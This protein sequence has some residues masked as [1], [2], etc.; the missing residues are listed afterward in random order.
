[1][2]I[3]KKGIFS[4]YFK[5]IIIPV[6]LFSFITGT[7]TGA[8]V[9]GYRYVATKIISYSQQIYSFLRNNLIYALLAVPFCIIITAV[10]RLFNKLTPDAKGGG[11]ANAIAF[12]RGLVTF[13][14]LRTLTGV[15]IGSLLTFLI[16]TP[17]GNEGPSV[18]SGSAIGCGVVETLGKKNKAWK[19]YI[20]TGGASAG[21]AVATNAPISGIML[22][23]E[24]AHHRLSPMLLMVSGATVSFA[25]I[26]S[27]IFSNLLGIDPNLF[28]SL[29][30]IVLEISDL[31]IP[32]VI[33]LIIGFFTVAF[34]KLIKFIRKKIVVSTTAF[35]KTLS[36]LLIF[37]CTVIFGLISQEFIGTGHHLIEHL[38]TDKSQPIY[39]LLIILLVRFL[40]TSAGTSAGIT[41]GTFIP[42]LAFGALISAS[43]AKILI[44]LG[45]NESYYQVIILL[46]M[47]ACI[48]GATKTPI[49]AMVFAFEALFLFTN[50]LSV[51]IVAI[52]SYIISEIFCPKSVNDEIMEFRVEEENENKE[53]QLVDTVLTV[54]ENSFAVGKQIRDIL[55]PNNFFVLSIKR[56]DTR[57]EIDEHGE[58]NMYP[59]D[60]LHVRYSTFNHSQTKEEISAIL[61]KQEFSESEWKEE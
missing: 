20:M 51:A 47:T 14:W 10:N 41:G 11:I 56:S 33:G 48:S 44:I 55:W 5:N 29:A 28:K 57:P 40:L 2:V 26:A 4:V 9:V 24:E 22:A 61:G 17:L 42:T 27:H 8:L 6:L 12:L 3:M 19:R 36:I 15:I 59:G 7:L 37:L 34:T 31:Y 21:F 53:R 43:I 38:L 30:P 35:K 52:V 58:K 23:L 45:L 60:K 25:I 1:M 50:V 54:Q 32:V 39:L 16:G 49:T 46:G 13:K 18:L